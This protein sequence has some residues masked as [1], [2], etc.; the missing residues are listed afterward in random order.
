VRRS[1]LKDNLALALLTTVMGDDMDLPQLAEL[2]ADLQAMSIAKYDGYEQYRPGVKFLESLAVWLN[3][4]A[5]AER[6]TA[7][8]FVR[9]RLVYV[10]AAEL[11]RLVATM[12]PDR[13]RPQLIE[14]AAREL[15]VPSWRASFIASSPEFAS[16]RRRTLL[17][18]MSD[19]ARLDRLRRSSPLST[20][21][22]HLVPQLDEP[23]ARA[24]KDRLANALTDATLPG[25]ATFNSLVLVDDFA[26]S[27]KTLARL[28]EG[29]P[30]VWTG[31]LVR[32]QVELERLRA[33]AD[34]PVRGRVGSGRL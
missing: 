3:S 24:M 28:D 25:E 17:L 29:D 22:F 31:K 5:P 9:R 34:R 30:T 10:S 18:G 2:T 27:G 32:A 15:G 8:S 20:E 16:L 1:Q 21:Q 6:A 23:K 33:R 4:F 26:A 13:I 7:L 11:D 12:Y 19:G 14:A